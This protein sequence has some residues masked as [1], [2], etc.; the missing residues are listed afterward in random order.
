MGERVSAIFTRM[1]FNNNIILRFTR[2]ANLNKI[3]KMLR[4]EL[5]TLALSKA[6]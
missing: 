5:Y 3:I 1:L 6:N 2:Y 4:T